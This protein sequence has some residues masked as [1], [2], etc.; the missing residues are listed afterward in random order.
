M[1]FTT[2]AQSG[3]HT[4]RPMATTAVLAFLALSGCGDHYLSG[5]RYVLGSISGDPLPA[6]SF[7]GDFARYLMLSDT[8]VLT[9]ATRGY[10]ASRIR[11]E[12]TEGSQ[13]VYSTST[14]FTYELTSPLE[15]GLLSADIAITFDCPPNA[16]CIEGPHLTG[17][18]EGSRL[19]LR[20]RYR[21]P[22]RLHVYNRR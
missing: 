10:Q 11:V 18:V 19:S 17:R 13:E 8:I 9:S 2:R 22:E 15:P 16:G 14:N 1:R 20:V 7:E 6:V 21:S 4:S 12:P 3:R 5:S